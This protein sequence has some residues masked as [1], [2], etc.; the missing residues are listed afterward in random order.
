MYVMQNK[1]CLAQFASYII[2]CA[3]NFKTTAVKNVFVMS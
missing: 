3:I 1:V 2:I